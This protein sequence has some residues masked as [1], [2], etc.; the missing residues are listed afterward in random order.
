MTARARAW[1]QASRPLAQVNIAVPL[2]FGSMV[3]YV[4]C[5]RLDI[6]L[7]VLAHV[8]GLFAQLFIVYA[9][10]LADEEG[11]RLNAT[12]S[13]FSG[14][15]RVLPEGK[16]DRRALSRGAIAAALAALVTMIV[17]A[18]AFERPAAPLLWAAS[19]VLLWAYSY[20]PLRLSYRGFGELAQGIGVGV[21]LPLVGFYM[22]AGTLG[23]FPWPALAPCFLLA[24]AS[25]INTALPDRVADEAVHK[26]T[27]PV[28]FGD[29]RARKHALQLVAL[30]A[31]ATP[32]V[33]PDL[34]HEGLAM[35]EAGPLL[36]LAI[37]AIALRR[38]G[39]SPSRRATVRF[40][41]VCGAA[42]NLALLGW[43]VAL[44]MRPPW[45]W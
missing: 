24:F 11:D 21:V 16:L 12:A 23:G 44:A 8:F 28:R 29:V 32:F 1:L 40:V 39:E 35:V 14:G 41:F 6:G 27:W 22:Q 20:P 3:A 30:A 15:S 31:L 4:E 38:Q 10:D 26:A 9:N 34:P 43:I 18:T 36:L 25:N 33:L 13:P 2:L 42:I 5:A 37:N 17:A 7:L 19:V 45:G